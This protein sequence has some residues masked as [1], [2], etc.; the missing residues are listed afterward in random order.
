MKMKMNVS[1]IAKSPM[2][3][4]RTSVIE[5]IVGRLITRRRSV[6]KMVR[7]RWF[8]RRFVRGFIRHVWRLR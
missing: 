5:L 4:K 2:T 6:M 7:G 8:V 3:V 1:T